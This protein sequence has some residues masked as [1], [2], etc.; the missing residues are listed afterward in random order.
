MARVSEVYFS[1][2]SALMKPHGLE[3]HFKL[4]TFVGE[5]S[6][7]YNQ[8]EIAE[9]LHR[10]KVSIFRSIDYLANRGLIE[11]KQDKDDRRCH[12]V[13]ITKKGEKLLPLIEESIAKTNKLILNDLND[14]EIELFS[15][16]MDHLMDRIKAL[17]APNYIV[18]PHRIK[19]ESND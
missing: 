18:K 8:G 6:A 16:V 13:L 2:L 3:R 9:I 17:P 7:K 5:H 15:S 1:T 11:R 12:R 19:K 14:T 4:L 10:D